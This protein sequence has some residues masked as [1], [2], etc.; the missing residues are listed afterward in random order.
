MIC[1]ISL[2][3]CLPILALAACGD[4]EP[5]T[6]IVLPDVPKTLRTPVQV[7]DREAQTLRD[8]GLILTDHVEALGK[9]NGRIVAIDKIL[10]QA[11]C[12]EGA[13]P[14]CAPQE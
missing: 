6:R 14:R 5:A 10:T 13:D 3:S 1:R 4:Q 7:P 9:A 8:V 12:L 11:E 2:W